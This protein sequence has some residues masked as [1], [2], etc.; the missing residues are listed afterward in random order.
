ML[1]LGIEKLRLMNKYKY[2]ISSDSKKETVGL[3]RAY[4][5]KQAIKKAS[6]KKQLD[7][8]VFVK[9]FNVEEVL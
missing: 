5:L 6:I 4:S 3:V 7:I 9:L 2:Y 8:D 1:Y